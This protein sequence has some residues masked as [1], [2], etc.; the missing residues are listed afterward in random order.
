MRRL[1]ARN[2]LV[3]AQVALS[4][5][6]L[7]SAG[8]FIK[9]TQNV[10][11]M[12]PG[13]ESKKIMLASVDVDL[14]GYDQAKGRSFFKQTV[15]RL[16]ALPGVEAASIGGPLPLDAYGNGSTLTVEG[17]VPRYENERIGVSYSI[18]GHD[19]FRCDEHSDRRRPVLHRARRSKRPACCRSQRNDC[20]SFLA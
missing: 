4:L 1:S 7:I 16:K 5:V 10:Q 8:L 20:A 19:Y 3:V 2:L 11:E 9:S 12:N 17:Y 6:L 15:E 13:F 14:Q 18:V